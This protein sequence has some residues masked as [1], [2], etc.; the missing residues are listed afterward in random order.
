MA[1]SDA[2]ELKARGFDVSVFTPDYDGRDKN[3]EAT[4]VSPVFAIGNAAFL[5]SLFTQLTGF[6]VAHLHYTFYGADVFVWLWSVLRRKPYVLTC[7]MRPET[8]DWRNTVFKVH[9]AL[10][11]PWILR[12]AH[13]VL[14]SSQDYARSIGV[15]HKNL[16]E[17]PFGVDE[18]RFCPG[19]DAVARAK[20]GI[21]DNV[22]TFVFVGGLDKAHSFK[23]VDV[24]I[25]AA[26]YLR[27]DK[28][29][30]LLIVGDGDMRAPYQ[31][32]ARAL[33]IAD[34]VLFLGAVSDTEL[35]HVYRAA[36]VH[37]L[38][39]TTQSEAFGLVTLEA[40]ASGLPSIVSDLPG[41]RTLIVP[42]Q[43]G[44]LVEPGIEESTEKAMQ[45][46]VDNPELAKTFGA[47]AR[48]RVLAN[49]TKKALAD[50]LAEVYKKFT[51]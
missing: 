21:P 9:R 6:D 48:E 25:R 28:D 51:A 38:P 41:V 13:T 35:P 46:F 8:Y 27:P 42:E 17:L 26:A 22:C 3:P 23:G 10:I 44:L 36:N 40:A 34:K 31:D 49:Y 33:G 50:R 16:V 47:H 14:V 7:H 12:G 5:P 39:S 11:E 4:Y 1:A 2:H 24:L 43:T 32:L 20:Y 29:W 37:V 19:T 30:R 15:Y 18:Q 45:R